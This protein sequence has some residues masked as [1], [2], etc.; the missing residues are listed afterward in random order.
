[1]NYDWIK[2]IKKGIRE[3]ILSA[4][5]K[6]LERIKQVLKEGSPISIEKEGYIITFF[7]VED[8]GIVEKLLAA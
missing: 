4:L 6:F 1:M 5:K 3:K 8:I 2:I 7:S